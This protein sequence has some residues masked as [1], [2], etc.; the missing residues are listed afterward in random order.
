MA[1]T[2]FDSLKSEVQRRNLMN[3]TREARKWLIYKARY[4][5]NIRKTTLGASVGT[6]VTGKMYFFVYD[7]KTK[8]K[9]PFYDVFPLMIPI[10]KYADGFLGLNLHYLPP[11]YRAALLD[12]LMFLATD[13]RMDERTRLKLSYSILDKHT[14]FMLFRPCVKRYL[15]SNIKSMFLRVEASEWKTVIFLPTEQFRKSKKETAWA[16]P[17][18][19]PQGM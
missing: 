8:D 2:L 3:R 1:Q 18:S 5:K 17:Q 19:I 9:L 10:K 4:M 6:I 7:P 11:Y 12:Q 14:R 13:S 16:L 15:Y